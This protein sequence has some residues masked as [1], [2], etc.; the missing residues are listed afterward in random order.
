MH[1]KTSR[2]LKWIPAYLWQR[3]TRRAPKGPVHLIIAL[4]DHFE[5]A[6]VEG[7][8]QARAPFDEQQRRLERWCNQ[9][10]AMADKWRDHEGRPLV[11]TYFYPAEQYDELLIERLAEF[12]HDGWGEVEIHLHHG[13]DA[14]DTAENTR[15]LLIEF[16]DRL[17]YKH[18]CLSYRRG[19]TVPGYAF[20]HGNFALA[21]SAEGWGCGVDSEM[22]ILAETGCYADLTL[23]T[24]P[25]HSAQTNKI[26]SLYECGIPLHKRAPHR[27]GRDLKRGSS[28]EVF[29]MIVQ[30]PL[31]I[32]FARYAASRWPRIE[33]AALTATNPATLRRFHL[34][35]QAAICV[36]GR[37]DW[38]FIKL[39]CH[40]MDPGQDEVLL[41]DPM[42][43]FLSE[44]VAGA[45][46]RREI[47]HFVSAREMA[48]IIVAACEGREGDPGDYRDYWLKRNRKDSSPAALQQNSQLIVKN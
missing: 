19:S 43:R 42:R 22:Q 15:R 29:P 28:P 30:G 4:A 8:G 2:G 45:D 12:C 47:L 10:P 20:V 40:G 31:M 17:A 5:P 38:L 24:A 16:R 18:G 1:R 6:Y 46:E 37:P 33:N 14:P 36:Q 48:N 9:Y 3:L 21:N 11:H 35:K 32:D 44:L 7:N 13:V 34:W 27:R 23:P 39:H 41:G 25:L 26:N